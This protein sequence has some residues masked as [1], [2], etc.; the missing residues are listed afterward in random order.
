MP[1]QQ[2]QSSE[3]SALFIEPPL[4]MHQGHHFHVAF[5]YQ[6]LL[7]Q[8]GY[9]P[10]VIHAVRHSLGVRRNWYP[11]FVL[12][13][14]TLGFREIRNSIE[15]KNVETYFFW[16]FRT[17]LTDH[18][19]DA[20]VFG[21]IRFI[22]IA[23]AALAS[24][25]HFHQRKGR[26]VFGVL[27]AADAPDC[28]DETFVGSAFQRAASILNAAMIDYC[29][30]VE[31]EPLKS[32]LIECGFLP[33]AIRIYQYVAAE[34]VAERSISDEPAQ[35][36]NVGYIGGTRP[37]RNPELMVNVICSGKVS[38]SVFWRVQID[39]NYI[40]RHMGVG[41]VDALNA[42]NESG[43][44]ALYPPNLDEQDYLALFRQL[45]FVVLPYSKRY[46]QIGSGLFTEA[47]YGL[48]TPIL[49]EASRLAQFYSSLAK[50]PPTFKG[51]S[52]LAIAD[53][54]E[55][56]VVSRIHFSANAAHAKQ[57]LLEHP[58]SAKLW[59]THMANWIGRADAD[60][61]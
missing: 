58:Q 19:P 32:F 36:V 12:P 20:C 28:S 3:S 24:A 48:V 18:D 11:H 46:E 33:D 53:A 7:R 6:E 9:E 49:P 41:F 22:N 31:S 27:E 44:I 54:I 10:R 60:S 51:L 56:A 57:S 38:S 47:I 42:L 2:H 26:V 1:M 4:A 30:V 34:R 50:H 61:Q 17:I 59:R 29:L 14:H 21:T 43:K 45:E 52:E 8:L 23:A 37:L 55:D 40:H 25:Q 13:H 39:L 35:R 16:E 5:A 15:L